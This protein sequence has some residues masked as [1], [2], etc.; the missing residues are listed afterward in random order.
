MCRYWVPPSF[1]PFLHQFRG[2]QIN[3]RYKLSFIFSSQTKKRTKHR[4]RKKTIRKDDPNQLSINEINALQTKQSNWGGGGVGKV[5]SSSSSYSSLTSTLVLLRLLFLNSALLI[6]LLLGLF[7]LKCLG[8]KI[9][10]HEALKISLTHSTK[11]N[12]SLDRIL[13]KLHSS[14]SQYLFKWC[15]TS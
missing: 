5:F 8:D 11:L 13:R 4:K 3:Q 2:I 6:L 12:H 1:F 14:I 15:G 10:I 9:T 7:F